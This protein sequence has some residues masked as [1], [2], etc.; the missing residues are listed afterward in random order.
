M[1]ILKKIASFVLASGVFLST[2]AYADTV[3]IAF[4]DPL[5]GPFATTGTGGLANWKFAVEKLVNEK[6]GVLGGKKNG[7]CCSRQQDGW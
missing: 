1:K 7:S 2:S 6:G 3:K 4:I 5:S